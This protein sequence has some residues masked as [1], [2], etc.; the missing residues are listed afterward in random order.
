MPIAKRIPQIG[1]FVYEYKCLCGKNVIYDAGE[2]PERLIP[3]FD[4]LKKIERG[5]LR[6]EREK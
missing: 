6:I 2:E 3:C 4:C 5:E 1:K